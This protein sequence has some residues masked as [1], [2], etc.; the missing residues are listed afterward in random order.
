MLLDKNKNY[1][2]TQLKASDTRELP[3]WDIF[4]LQKIQEI[5]KTCAVILDFGDSSRALSDLFSYELK[6]KN[7]LTVDINESYNPNIVADI[8][9]LNMFENESIDG[10]IC[11]AIFEHVYNPFSAV[12]ELFRVM[13][14][15]GKM[16]VYV[17]WMFK[18]HAPSNGEYLDFFR[19]S[20]DGV[21]YLFKDFSNIE[22][23][24]VRGHI[25]TILNLIPR[26]GKGS[27]F[28]RIFGKIIRKIDRYDETHT[29]GFNIFL[30]K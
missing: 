2:F 25:E 3:S 12:S 30:N 27:R 21:C 26:L 4:R 16:F 8:C 24:P 10:I 19:Y 13:K 1:G 9:N 11:T 23:C 7:R 15:S 5:F 20:R 17:P 28:I 6:N 18:Y 29:S 22:I 14:P